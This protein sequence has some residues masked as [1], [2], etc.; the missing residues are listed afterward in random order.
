MRY[1]LALGAAVVV[2]LLL[3][4]DLGPA[5][6]RTGLG[7]TLYVLAGIFGVLTLRPR[8]APLPVCAG[9][10]TATCAIELLQLW[11]PPFLQAA[12]ATLAGQLLLGSTFAWSDF[13]YY[14][15]GAVLGYFLARRLTS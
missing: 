4:L 1:L 11:H 8:L 7:G 2:G 15:A 12:R 9:V 10:L 14:L 6:L 13:P 3:L 5:W